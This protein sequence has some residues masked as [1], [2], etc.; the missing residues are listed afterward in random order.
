MNLQ[1]KQLQSSALPIELHGL[2]YLEISGS[3][4]EMAIRKIAVLPVKLYPLVKLNTVLPIKLYPF[5]TSYE[6]H[7]THTNLIACPLAIAQ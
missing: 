5:L 1:P 4:P 6:L 2:G 3:E 7:Y